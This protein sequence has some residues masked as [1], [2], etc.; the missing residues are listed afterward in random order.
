MHS[1]ALMV[2]LI[3]KQPL[4]ADWHERKAEGWAWYEER[5]A[6]EE[7]EEPDQEE[8]KPLSSSE[9]ILEV[10]K[11]LEEK[12]ANAVLDPSPENVQSYME[13]Q[14]KWTERSS[15]FAKVWTQLLLNQPQ[16]DYTATQRPVSQYGLQLY[17]K[18]IQEEKERLIGSLVGDYGL[19]FFYAG[20]DQASEVFGKIV[21]ELEK[22]Y[23]WKTIAISTDGKYLKD[24]EDTK[25]DNGAA[26]ALEVD[27]V[28]A[29]YL[30]NPKDNIAVPISFGLVALDQIENNIVLQFKETMEREDG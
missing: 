2:L 28:P 9:Q 29:L 18:R 17:K 20:A 19:F 25:K 24:F 10:R 13:E 7:H 21:Q 30:I 5:R 14:Q 22:K 4:C 27:L 11:N 23:G 26:K 3:G 16:L 8:E 12:L 15:H 6:L 1:L